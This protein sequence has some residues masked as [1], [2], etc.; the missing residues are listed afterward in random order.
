MIFIYLLLQ[1]AITNLFITIYTGGILEARYKGNGSTIQ[2]KTSLEALIGDNIYDERDYFNDIINHKFISIEKG[3]DALLEKPGQKI[4]DFTLLCQVS[5]KNCGKTVDDYK[6]L[7]VRY[8]QSNLYTEFEEG[9]VDR[10]MEHYKDKCCTLLTNSVVSTI[11]QYPKIL[12]VV[13]SSG[14]SDE[15]IVPKTNVQS[16]INFFDQIYELNGCIY[17]SGDHYTCRVYSQY[18]KSI[19]VN[20]PTINNS[21]F[22]RTDDDQFPSENIKL[23]I[24]VNK[25]HLKVWNNNKNQTLVQ[26]LTNVSDSDD[27]SQQLMFPDH[28]HSNHASIPVSLFGSFCQNGTPNSLS[29]F[30]I[31]DSDVLNSDC[32]LEENKN[33]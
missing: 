31:Y 19:L 4:C 30:N 17:L 32:I 26:L 27:I 15:K 21:I 14:N 10:S 29:D 1:H 9:W 2:S 25:Q 11:Q 28:L 5:C 22:L 8:L 3:I 6:R 12:F 18:Y 24:Y 23:A 7:T 16:E 20:D 13:H 33:N